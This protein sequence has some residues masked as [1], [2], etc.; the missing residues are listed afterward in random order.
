M[1]IH[2]RESSPTDGPVQE[3]IPHSGVHHDEAPVHESDVPLSEEVLVTPDSPA[4][5][6]TRHQSDNRSF[7]QKHKKGIA[8]AAIGPILGMG[9][10]IG[11]KKAFTDPIEEALNNP[12]P[13]N[14]APVD[15]GEVDSSNTYVPP[16]DATAWLAEDYFEMRDNPMKLSPE[17]LSAWESGD[18]SLQN[19]V[20]SD[21]FAPRL[22]IALT[23]AYRAMEQGKDV[24][25]SWFTSDPT[26]VSEVNRIAS[27]YLRDVAPVLDSEGAT[28]HGINVCRTNVDYD[29]TIEMCA[30]ENNASGLS[31][32][33]SPSHPN[34]GLFL[35]RVTTEDTTG[36]DRSETD[37]NNIANFNYFEIDGQLTLTGDQLTISSN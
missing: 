33:F 12:N 3:Q 37:P 26:V 8:A 28:L 9:T 6:D 14:S 23:E 13:G 19:D 36:A 11:V 15:P 27:H 18:E 22:Q 16:K 1:S 10:F 17:Q 2:D 30:A 31:I 34:I 21:V 35:S 29:P 24:D 32:H 7:F 4:Q 20:A 5:L 25:L